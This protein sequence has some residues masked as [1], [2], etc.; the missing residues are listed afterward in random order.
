MDDKTGAIEVSELASLLNKQYK[1]NQ[2]ELSRLSDSLER[3]IEKGESKEYIDTI[4]E[5]SERL[6]NA[7][8]AQSNSANEFYKELVKMAGGRQDIDPNVMK[9]IY[10]FMVENV[11][12]RDRIENLEKQKYSERH[13]VDEEGRHIPARLA[14]IRKYNEEI[15]ELKEKLKKMPQEFYD[16]HGEKTYAGQYV[17][18]FVKKNKEAL[19][20]QKRIHDAIIGAQESQKDNWEK[21]NKATAANNKL[22]AENARRAKELRDR[23]TA[24]KVTLEAMW[25]KT[26]EGGNMWLKINEQAISDAKRLGIVTRDGAL[27]YTKHLLENTQALSRNFGMTAEQAMKMQDA[28]IKVTGRASMLTTSQMEDIAAATK[29]MGAETVQ[30]AMQMMDTMGSTSQTTTELLD[31][32][33]AR[34]VNSGL[35]TVKA[36][37]EFVKNM[38]LANQL[39]FRNGVDGISRMTI[40]SQTIKMNFQEVARVADKF[41]TIEGAIEGAARLQMLGGPVAMLGG[42]PMQMLYESL[43]D[44]EALFERIKDMA[45]TQ[46][47]FNRKTGEAEI[48]PMTL[49]FMKEQEKALGVSPGTLIGSAKQQAKIQAI[50]SDFRRFSP[51]TYQA[52]TPEQKMALSNKAEYDKELGTWVIKYMDEFGKEQRADMRN[53]TTAQLAEISKDNIDPVNDIKANVRK[54]A[55]EL[56]GTKERWNSMKEQINLGIGGALHGIMKSGDSLLTWLN[57]SAI[58]KM[59]TTTA[60]GAATIIAGRGLWALGK[61]QLAKLFSRGLANYATTGKVFGAASKSGSGLSFAA[62]RNLVNSGFRGRLISQANAAKSIATETGVASQGAKSTRLFKG[63]GGLK[64]LPKAVKFGGPATAAIGGLMY[65]IGG[66]Y[67]A[68]AEKKREDALIENAQKNNIRFTDTEFTQRRLAAENKKAE[69]TS[70]ALAGGIGMTAG[71]ILGGALGTLIAPGVGSLIGSAIGGYV[72]E[73]LGSSFGKSIASHKQLDLV[74]EHLEAINKSDSKENFRRIVLPVESIDYNVSLIANRLGINWAQPSRGNIYLDAEAAGQIYA[75][76]VPLSGGEHVNEVDAYKVKASDLYKPTGPLTL[77]INGALELNL[78]GTNVGQIKAEDFKKMLDSN[79]EIVRYLAG[80]IIKRTGRN[81][82]GSNTTNDNPYVHR[83]SV[84][85]NE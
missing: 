77:N 48:D 38:S 33:F 28:Y 73:K 83:N 57:S 24:I 7:I 26:K 52:A 39:S 34:A 25:N 49:A 22:L 42:N 61:F 31:R 23:W 81:G 47:V 85:T 67:E 6:S 79:P 80:E 35:D 14:E 60:V 69:A 4:K 72:G 37:Q 1:R 10:K 2:R 43:S 74:G 20:K 84:I 19:E 76:G 53:I 12:I 41:S 56:I 78:K 63:V 66:S 45:A 58:W 11:K 21:I 54:I 71:T 62:R 50:E 16:K 32:N 51:A 59:L 68:S 70:S 46:A 55:Q 40:L 27:N 44:P 17:K 36:S 13:K 18:G 65:A 29:L 15:D 82:T 64:S 8:N 5:E 75:K 3:A 30:S 9:D